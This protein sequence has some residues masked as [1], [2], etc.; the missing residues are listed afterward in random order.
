MITDDDIPELD[1]ATDENGDKWQYSATTGSALAVKKTIKHPIYA[2]SPIETIPTPSRQMP[3]AEKF[4][5]N[6]FI[7]SQLILD[8]KGSR[9]KERIMADYGVGERNAQRLIKQ[10]RNALGKLQPAEIAS[11]MLQWHTKQRI[12][13][14]E[15]ND[16]ADRD[17]LETLKDLARLQRLYDTSVTVRTTTAD[18]VPDHDL[19]ALAVGMGGGASVG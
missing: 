7:V 5:L 17:K 8:T 16:I 4:E 10:C 12:A 11:E 6:R 18:G 13:L 3:K 19:M 9:I 1:L 15:S 14:I 2:G